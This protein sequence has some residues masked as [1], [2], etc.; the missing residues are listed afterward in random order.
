MASQGMDPDRL[1][2]LA[3]ELGRKA[4][5]RRAGAQSDLVL[6][7]SLINPAFD[8]IEQRH[9]RPKGIPT[10]Y[11][12]V[13]E[14]LGGMRRKELILLAGATGMGKSIAVVDICRHVAIRQ[15]LSVALFTLEMAKEEVFE[16]VLSAESGVPHDRIRDGLPSDA[17]EWSQIERRIGPMANAPFYV[18]DRA[19]MRV[20]DIERCC[21]QML[22]SPAGLDLVAID[23]MH[24]LRA[25]TDRIT[26]PNQRVADVST[27]LKNMAMALDVPVLSAAQFNRAPAARM[28]KTPQMSD[29]RGASNIEQDANKIILVHRPDYY[30]RDSPRGGEVDLIVAKNRSG[31]TK[32]VTVAAQLHLSR[33]A[34]MS[35]A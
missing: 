25:S 34:D 35:I 15:R 1:A 17:P 2:E 33:F 6:L 5:A 3:L 16:R 20:A 26:D 32:V 22:E 7:G 24:L 28:D 14:V 13:D 9:T 8:D 18:S 31:R 29:L 12:E 11:S 10:G 21:R 19:P 30:D 4:Q 27:S 23:H